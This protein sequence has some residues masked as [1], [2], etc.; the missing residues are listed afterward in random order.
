MGSDLLAFVDDLVGCL[1]DGGADKNGDKM[2][3]CA[4]G[5]RDTT[6]WARSSA[7]TSSR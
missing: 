5:D 7:D 4:T 1:D 3:A 2:S 6:A